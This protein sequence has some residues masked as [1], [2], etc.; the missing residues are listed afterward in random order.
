MG[1]GFIFSAEGSD[2]KAT[3]PKYN[4]KSRPLCCVLAANRLAAPTK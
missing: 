1:R 4:Y 2:G 3:V